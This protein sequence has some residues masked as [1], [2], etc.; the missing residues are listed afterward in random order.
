MKKYIENRESVVELLESK[1]FKYYIPRK[2]EVLN[3]W[4]TKNK[5]YYI[6]LSENDKLI[7][8]SV[9]AIENNSICAEQLF[10]DCNRAYDFPTKEDGEL[11]YKERLEF[12]ELLY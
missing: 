12:E 10:Y 3:K 11:T 2:S 7:Y 9:V 6:E 4:S 5:S 8:C 1:G